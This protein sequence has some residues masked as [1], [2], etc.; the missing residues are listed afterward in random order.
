MAYR[1]DCRVH[2]MEECAHSE[3]VGVQ[4]INGCLQHSKMKT[5][6][7][8]TIAILALT[9]LIP[10][11]QAQPWPK[12]S[13]PIERI[14]KKEQVEK[15]GPGSQ[16]LLVCKSSD[17]ITLID[18]KNKKQALALCEQGHM[19][20]CKDC[21][22]KFKVVWKNPTGKGDGQKTV[23]E[24]VNSKGEPCMFLARLK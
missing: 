20:E 11:A 19:I 23:M 14:Q 9:V 3:S 10:A 15:L 21:R 7:K 2:P 16:L 13:A 6:S 17:T 22:K 1:E 5:I 4:S 24:I 18:I 12:T 8:L